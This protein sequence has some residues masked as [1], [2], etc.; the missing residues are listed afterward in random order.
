M[1]N[2]RHEDIEVFESVSAAPVKT[3]APGELVLATVCGFDHAGQVLV[4]IDDAEPLNAL[5]TVAVEP[6]HLGQQ[7]A[8]M[9]V[10]GD[11]RRPVIIGLIRSHLDA[12]LDATASA[13]AS[14]DGQ[15]EA[16]A[17]AVAGERVPDAPAT[18]VIVDGKRLVLQGEEEIVLKCGDSSITLTKSGKI[19]IRGKYLL[20]RSSGVNRIMGG[21][22][23][24]N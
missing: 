17:T 8:L 5:A 20:N 16:P 19:V 21:S 12:V 15:V 22:V 1:E 4:S 24:V 7:V 10:N 6:R 23:Q 11:T 3:A 18:D 13:A 9:F 14:S 2:D